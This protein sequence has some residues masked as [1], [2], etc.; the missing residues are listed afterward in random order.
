M[1][2]ASIALVRPQIV[3]VKQDAA[4]RRRHYCGD[5]RPIGELPLTRLEIV[6]AGLHRKRYGQR[7]SHLPDRGNRRLHSRWGL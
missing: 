4:V 5:E 1:R 3:E 7:L 6:H 2:L